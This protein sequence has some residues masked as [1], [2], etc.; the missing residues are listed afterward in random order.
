MSKKKC[1]LC[2]GE[3]I[4]YNCYICGCGMCL[5]HEI[6]VPHKGSSVCICYKC[7]STINHIVENVD[8]CK[9]EV[10]EKAKEVLVEQLRS[11][12][13]VLKLTRWVSTNEKP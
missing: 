13:T 11:G 9:K 12:T 2:E 6:T 7:Y 1:D 3:D 10:E 5:I 4:R 8:K